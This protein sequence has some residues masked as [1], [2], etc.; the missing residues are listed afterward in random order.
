M[1]P[2]HAHPQ[3]YAWGSAE[4][5]PRFLG[6]DPD[7]RAWAELWYG[8]H[9]SAP[10]I[11]DA[12]GP[13]D[14]AVTGDPRGMLGDDVVNAFGSRLPYLLKLIAPERPLS[15]QVHPSRSHAAESFAAENAA[16]L[17]LDSPH[18]N[19]R[20]DNHKPEMV[21][22][23]TKF[24]AVCGFR[25]PRRAAQIL[26]GLDTDLSDRLHTLLVENLSAH[27]M[28][29][30]FRTLV[31]PSLRPDAAAVAE[32]VAACE[33]RV[34]AGASPSP[35]ID[36]TVVRLHEHFPGDPGVVANLLLNPVTLQPG[37]AMYVPEGAI[38]AYLSGFGVEV[39]AASDNVLRAGLTAKR[40]DV[41]EMLQCVSVQ[42]APPQRVAPERLTPSTVAY[43]APIDDFQLSVTTLDGGGDVADPVARYLVP[44]S[45]PRI[46]LCL[47][48]ELTV[49][50]G[51]S[52]L[53]LPAGR[54]VF[55]AAEDGDLHVAGQGR[56][57]QA[58]VP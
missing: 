32:V 44:G 3:H 58:S 48:G 27:G 49:S 11:L 37:E 36:R 53:R 51:G 9:P 29:A 50:A 15:L 43:F 4:E 6:R 2:L 30:A 20:D 21:L 13:L 34:A 46:L 47:D 31:S 39:M 12:A 41:E 19:Y 23:L 38:H 17:P 55:V 24:E 8:A 14:A 22:A 10:S 42:A 45:G 33:A 16:G 35:R 25:A 52:T 40:V 5:L 18:R 56:V 28:R 1:R 57:I 7:G 54:A 26:A